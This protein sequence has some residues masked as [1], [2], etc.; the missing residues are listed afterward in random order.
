MIF[1]RTSK[2]LRMIMATLCISATFMGFMIIT[3]QPAQAFTI[4]PGG[5]ITSDTTWTVAGSP[6]IVQN[7][8]RV[9]NG[10]TLTI[11]PGVWVKIRKDVGQHIFVDGTLIAEGTSSNMIHF[12][13]NASSPAEKDWGNIWINSTGKAIINYINASYGNMIV[14][15]YYASDIN[16]TNSVF[17]SNYAGVKFNHGTYNLITNSTFSQ[18]QVG[19]IIENSENNTVRN[20]TFILSNIY[21]VASKLVSLNNIIFH[22]RFIDGFQIP[23]GSDEGDSNSWNDTYPSGGNYWNDYD[24]PIEGCVDDFDGAITPQT[25]GFPDGICDNPYYLDADSADY[26]PFILKQDL[27]PPTISSVVA[28]PDPQEVNGFVNVSAIVNDNLQLGG[29]W[30]NITDPIGSTEGNYSMDYDV[31]NDE[32]FRNSSY[33]IPGLYQFTVWAIDTSGNWNSSFGSFLMVDTTLPL[34]KDVI[35]NPNPQDAGGIVNVSANITDNAEVYNAWINIT[36]KGNFSLD[37]DALTARYYR[38][39]S[40]SFAGTYPYMIW[41]NDTSDNWNSTGGSIIIQDI[42]PPQTTASVASPYWKN[43]QTFDV[44]WIATDNQGLSNVTLQYRNSSNNI[45]WS[46]WNEYSYNDSVSGSSASGS[47]Q[48][49]ASSD[50]YYEFFSN[51]S[52]IAGNWESDSPTAEAI[53]AV[54]TVLPTSILDAISPYWR[55]TSPLSLGGAATDALS[56]I[57]EVA[58]WYRYSSNNA[59]WGS[60][61]SFGTDMNQPWSWSYNF[62]LGEGFYEFYSIANDNASNI[63]SKS[64]RESLCAFDIT[65][66]I[67]YAGSDQNLGLDTTII[68]D[69]S[70]SSD[71]L[72]P[73]ANYTW[74]IKD[75][76]ITIATLFGPNP[77]HLFD[78]VGDFT[79]TLTV[80]DQTGNS[81]NHSIAISVIV[82]S[83]APGIL[84]DANPATQE[85]HGNVNVTA[86]VTDDVEVFG[87]WIQIFNPDGNELENIS[88]NRIGTTDNYWHERTFSIVGTFLYSIWT[89]DTSSNWAFESGNFVMQDTTLPTADAGNDRSIFAGGLTYLD[90]AGS[91][92]NVGIIN[93]TWS[94]TLNGLPIATLFGENQSIS[95]DEVGTYQVELT[96]RDASG[97]E[98]K[99]TINITVSQR[100]PD[101][102]QQDYWWIIVLIAI[103]IVAIVLLLLFLRRRKKGDKP[104]IEE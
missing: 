84:H 23:Q 97:N 54:D 46:S 10:V 30:I 104:P 66:P 16:V 53:A 70:S 38:N 78:A 18:N 49:T 47:F 14:Y 26:Y 90:G 100:P 50:G 37:Y 74:T 31:P 68:F 55:D 85:V 59:S 67:A 61:S 41:T 98:D 24:E 77:S 65:P 82:D 36:G 83:T 13:S 94:I 92:D 91:E 56:G 22:N 62:P 86:T 6:Y 28:V 89:H 11:E 39:D 2:Q 33:S 8:I 96:V 3:T 52:D 51:A 64:T 40:Y 42:S 75:G 101:E 12:T 95:F 72:G 44:N 48:F 9:I 88:M 4:I 5:S 29:V 102:S 25:T 93:Y 79:V 57:K 99:D 7:S 45:S 1:K 27:E 69:G 32:Y 71:N 17:T 87:V 60:W 21:G 58:L 19:V 20:N 103:V 43:Q 81:G 73:I 35:E 80:V 63:E 34:I 15:L 76:A